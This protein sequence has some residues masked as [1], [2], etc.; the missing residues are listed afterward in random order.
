MFAAL[1][2]IDCLPRSAKRNEGKVLFRI[3]SLLVLLVSTGCGVFRPGIPGSGILHSENR[4]VEAFDQV[5]LSGFGEVEILV[6]YSPSVR[7]TTDDNLLA[8]VDTRVE[9]GKLVIKPRQSIHPRTGLKVDVTVPSLAAA[10]VRGAG[11]LIIHNVAGERLELSISGAG[12]VH[13]SGQVHEISTSISG[14]G[15]ADLRNLVSESADVRV[16]GAGDIW[17]NATESIKAR[18]SGAGDVVCFG[19]PVHIDQRVSGAGDFSIQ[20]AVTTSKVSAKGLPY[21]IFD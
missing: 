9:N 17:V 8:L 16:S 4:H 11:D 19:N 15:D 1:Q 6:G 12:T 18:V 5:D 21:T 7:V 2:P 10:H 14:A 3:F 20:P 13:A